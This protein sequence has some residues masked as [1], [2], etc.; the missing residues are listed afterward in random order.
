MIPVATQ[1]QL[2]GARK[3]AVL[4]LAMGPEDASRILKQL[5]PAELESVMREIAAIPEVEDGLVREVLQEYR[6]AAGSGDRSVAGG[7]GAARALLTGVVGAQKA[8]AMLDGIRDR[9]AGE[10]LARLERLDP[11]ALAGVLAEE[12][13][14]TAAVVLAH[15]DLKRASK[16]LD[17]LRPELASDVLLRMARLDRIAPDLLS[18][19]ADGIEAKARAATLEETITPGD[20]ARVARLL[21]LAGQGRDEEILEKM[22]G[23]DDD[24]AAR[25]KALMFVFEDLILVEGKG[26]QRILRDVEQKDLALALKGASEEVTQHITSNMSERAAA[27]LR[28]EVELLGTVRVKDVEEAQTRILEGV[29]ELENEGEVVVRRAGDGDEYL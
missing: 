9:M 3:T 16:V 25:I 10:K 24:L 1:S 7:F 29:R 6:Q 19:V 26:I 27:A 8:G 23:Q 14:Q 15:F 28:E 18:L 22:R 13:P 2:T 12:H 5:T 4:C 17:R 11:Q 20:P 21:N